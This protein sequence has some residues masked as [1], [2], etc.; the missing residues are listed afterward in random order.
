VLSNRADLIS[1]GDALVEVVLSSSSFSSIAGVDVDGRDVT[2]AFAVGTDGRYVGLVTGLADGVNVLRATLTDGSGARISITNHPSGGPVFGGPQ[3]QPW[4]CNAGANDSSCSRLPTYQYF[5]VPVGI[6]PQTVPGTINGP[7]GPDAYFQ[8]YDPANPPAPALIAQTT[9]DQGKTVPFVVRVETG[10]LGR[11]QYQIA[12]LFDSAKPWTL[13][14]PQQAWNHKLF[15]IGGASCG[16]SYQEG[17]A[18]GLLYG[19]VLGRGFALISSALDVTGNDCNLVTQAEALS[20]AKEH[21]I[22]AYGTVRYTMSIGGSGA[23]IVQH[24]IANA[25]PGLFDGLIVEA[26]FPDAWTNSSTRKTAS[27]L[28]Y[29]TDP[30][31]WAP[32]VDRPAEQSFVGKCMYRKLRAFGGP[33][34]LFTP[35]DSGKSRQRRVLHQGPPGWRAR[36][37]LGL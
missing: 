34:G 1:G 3:V 33:K 9:T 16:V 25:Y 13:A 12:V 21:L 7:T 11:A 17:T 37:D 15:M 10:S 18:P 28:G 27:L 29:W 14:Q 8:T 23:S 30:T 5:Y 31:K 36:H 2:S 24:W 35:A 22:E 19:K 4:S 32:G 20:M 26:S 6:D